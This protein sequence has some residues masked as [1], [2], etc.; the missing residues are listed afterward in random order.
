M[1]SVRWF[2]CLAFLLAVKGGES[3]LPQRQT[4][5]LILVMAD[6]VRWQEVFRGASAELLE[7]EAAD[8]PPEWFSG[9]LSGRRRAIMPWVWTYLRSHGQ[10]L[11][12]RDKGS[13]MEVAN[14][15]HLSYPGF[16]ETLC[17]F[18]VPGLEGNQSIWNPVASIL[19]RIE[20]TPGFRG[21][22]AAFATWR[23]FPWILR[24]SACGFPVI[25]G[26]D[27]VPEQGMPA[28]VVELNRRKRVEKRRFPTGP[29]DELTVEGAVA[30]LA[31]AKP[32]LLLV[33]LD[34]P[35]EWAHE[36]CYVGY[37]RAIQ[38][39]DTALRRLWET[40]GTIPEFRG[41]TTLIVTTDHGRGASPADWRNHG[42]IREAEETWLM[43][44]GPDTP[45]R[46][47]VEAGECVS[48]AQV[49]STVSEICGV[50][51]LRLE[52]RAARPIKGLLAP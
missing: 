51:Y 18:P 36:G 12:N 10:I 13:R 21:R 48:N 1:S 14:R 16:A 17:G 49:A 31:A 5:C 15:A 47:E 2:M 28:E 32:R 38:A 22:V 27:P 52:P 40:A 25:S 9:G 8:C 46:G 45:N 42:G 29:A 43:A 34:E 26:D 44:L 35:D 24:K 4:R 23:H 41:R 3:P 50:P 39:T 19:E 6:G 33:V 7:S 30:Y 11:G 20:P 37:L